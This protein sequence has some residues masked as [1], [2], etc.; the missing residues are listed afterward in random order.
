MV[1]KED[2]EF[3]INEK[4]KDCVREETSVVSGTSEMSVQNRQLKQLH[5]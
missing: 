2:K 5:P 3:A 1:W 4:Q